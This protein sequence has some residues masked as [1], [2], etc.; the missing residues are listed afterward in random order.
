MEWVEVISQLVSN[1]GFPI[2]CCGVMFYLA[3]K[4]G[5]NINTGLAEV[6][7]GVDSVAQS[8]AKLSESIDKL[9]ETGGKDG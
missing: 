6:K 3:Y 8:I 7:V 2:A 1:V 4:F 9:L 5:N